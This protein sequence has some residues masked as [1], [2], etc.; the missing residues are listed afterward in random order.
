ML[1]HQRIDLTGVPCAV[2][3]EASVNDLLPSP[4]HTRAKHLHLPS[5]ISGVILAI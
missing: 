5:N 1:A 3:I 4:D 2:K